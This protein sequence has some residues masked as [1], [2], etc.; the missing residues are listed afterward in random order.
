MILL[1]K[2]NE[3][4]NTCYDE[5][6]I[7]DVVKFKSIAD[8]YKNGKLY[9]KS[10]TSVYGIIDGVD[11]NGWCAD[12]AAIYF[13][14]FYTKDTKGNKITIN[15]DLVIDGFEVLKFKSGRTKQFFNYFSTFVS[16]KE[17]AI[18]DVDR[19]VIFVLIAD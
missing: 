19:N 16:G 8:V 7:L 12:N 2:N 1:L 9:I 15:S 14:K 6:E 13:K 5:L 10:D 17:V 18:K 3:P 4:I 11:E